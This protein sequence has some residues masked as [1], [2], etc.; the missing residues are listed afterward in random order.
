MAQR[1]R[2]SERSCH[3]RSSRFRKTHFYS[4]TRTTRQKQPTVRGAWCFVSFAKMLDMSYLLTRTSDLVPFFYNHV[5]F[6][7]SIRWQ[8]A[9][10]CLSQIL[11]ETRPLKPSIL[12][13]LY[14]DAPLTCSNAYY[15]IPLCMY[16]LA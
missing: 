7:R 5:F 13:F 12:P 16:D 8:T 10:G 9:V 1:A 2:L 15:I 4:Q 14:F 3:S 11:F 6:S